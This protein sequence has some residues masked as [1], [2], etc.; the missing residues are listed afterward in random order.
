MHRKTCD[1]CMQAPCDTRCPNAVHDRRGS[2]FLCGA[3]LFVG[4]RFFS[5][6]DFGFK[7]DFLICEECIT[8][9]IQKLFGKTVE[10]QTPWHEKE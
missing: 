8:E 9:Y 10:E 7:G 6:R 1:I 3:P 4:D 5:N 2:C